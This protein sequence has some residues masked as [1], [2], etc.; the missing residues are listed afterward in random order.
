MVTITEVTGLAIND[1]ALTPNLLAEKVEG[2]IADLEAQ[3][4]KAKRSERKS[5]NSRLHTARILLRWAK[6]RAGYR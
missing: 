2:L 4:A 1:P 6:S 5:L 3:R